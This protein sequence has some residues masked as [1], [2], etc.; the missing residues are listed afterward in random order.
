MKRGWL[1][2]MV[3]KGMKDKSWFSYELAESL[4]LET[5]QVSRIMIHLNSLGAITQSGGKYRRVE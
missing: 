3:L 2:R 1:T 4:G 5:C